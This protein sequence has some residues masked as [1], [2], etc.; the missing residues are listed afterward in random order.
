[1]I[2]RLRAGE[3]GPC[4]FSTCVGVVAGAMSGTIRGSELQAASSNG[5]NA[6]RQPV[7]RI[8]FVIVFRI[9]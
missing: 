9:A 8:D 4:E 7:I 6:T 2:A 5:H 1:M 3:R